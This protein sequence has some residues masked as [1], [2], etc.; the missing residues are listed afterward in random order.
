[1]M[2]MKKRTIA[3][4]LSVLLFMMASIPVFAEEA[5]TEASGAGENVKPYLAMGANLK[6]NEKAAVLELLGLSG[7]DLS[8]YDIIQITNEDEKSY[9]GEYLPADVIGSRSLSSVLVEK[10]E[11]GHGVVVTTKNIS[12]CTTGMYR[13]ALLTAGIED[14]DI[15]VAGPFPITGTAALVG[16]MKAYS[17]MTGEKISQESMDAATNELVVTGE[18][19]D[20]VGDSEKIEELIAFV[21]QQVLEKGLESEAEIKAAVTEAAKQLNIE[22][23]AEN[24]DKIAALMSKIAGLDIDFESLK[25]QAEEL[26]DKLEDLNIDTDGII[27][28]VSNFFSKLAEAIMEFF[29]GLLG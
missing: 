12:Y 3:T 11:K 9:L 8:G 18:L 2:K 4:V 19:A 10:R 16:A 15:T 27:E 5:Q 26:Y 14:A 29:K 13:N 6:E 21:K 20:A 7:K 17:I 25:K 24:I 28:K 22:L 23:T 1:M